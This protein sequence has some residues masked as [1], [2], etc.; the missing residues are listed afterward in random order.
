MGYRFAALPLALAIVCAG[1]G[2]GS[3]ISKALLPGGNISNASIDIAC[4]AVSGQN[5]SAPFLTGQSL[6]C[7]ASQGGST[8]AVDWRTSAGTIS[9]DGSLTKVHTPGLVVVS[10][11]RDSSQSSKTFQFIAL[12][13]APGLI[14]N[15]DTKVAGPIWGLTMDSRQNIYGAGWVVNS[16]IVTGML[17]SMDFWERS[18]KSYSLNSQSM[19]STGLTVEDTP[20]FAGSTIT[21][22]AESPLILSTDKSPKPLLSGACAESG[23]ITALAYDATLRI[24]WSTSTQALI[25]EIDP[26]TLQINCPSTHDVLT[27]I[28]D[29][30]STPYV[31]SL[32]TFSG[33]TVASGDFTSAAGIPTGFI[34]TLDHSDNT[35]SQKLFPFLTGIRITPPAVENGQIFFYAAGHQSDSTQDAWS[36]LKL[37]QT[38]NEVWTQTWAGNSKGRNEPLAIVL[39]PAGGIVAAGSSTQL[40]SADPTA[41]DAILLAYGPDGSQ[42][43]AALRISPNQPNSQGSNPSTYFASLAVTPDQ[44]FLIAAGGGNQSAS[45]SFI[46]GFVLP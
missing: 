36:I 2:S 10:A 19:F 34:L 5:T 25:A 14:F 38:L 7:G 18:P 13:G 46:L 42:P 12:F 23:V 6:R 4:N 27:G 24:L 22:P 43:W 20:L 17:Y 31:L 35:L 11:T 8:I 30:P 41:T 16:G 45:R 3:E 39:N 32:Q 15:V 1:C 40:S 28:S 33:G 44:K 26:K 37:D 29:P 21:P 9:A